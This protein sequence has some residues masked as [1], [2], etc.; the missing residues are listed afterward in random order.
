VVGRRARMPEGAPAEFQPY[1]AKYWILYTVQ[2][3]LPDAAGLPCNLRS[4]QGGCLRDL[5]PSG[6]SGRWS[7]SGR[8]LLNP[9]C[10]ALM[11]YLLQ[12]NHSSAPRAKGDASQADALSLQYRVQAQLYEY[13]V[14]LPGRLLVPT[15]PKVSM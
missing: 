1:A 10:M 2:G 4:D 14:A 8:L 12:N 11:G 5:E 6:V 15:R 7:S 9:A 3:C 13:L